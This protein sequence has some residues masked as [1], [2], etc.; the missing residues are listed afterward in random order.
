M[1]KLKD[2]KA[3]HLGQHPHFTYKK[4]H[5]ETK[6]PNYTPEGNNIPISQGTRVLVFTSL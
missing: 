6:T 2:L 4:T 3:A 5:P 1:I